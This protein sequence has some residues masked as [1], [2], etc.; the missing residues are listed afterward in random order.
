MRN[1]HRIAENVNVT[2]LMH[3][4]IRNRHLWNENRFRTEFP[5]TPHVDVDDIWLRFS[6]ASKCDTTSTVIGD[7][8]P[9]WYPARE[10]LN[11]ARPIILDLMRAVG[12]YELGRVLITRIPKG[13]K[14]LPHRDAAGEYVQNP[15]I[16]RYHVV[17]QGEEGSLY[18]C[19][20]GTDESPAEVVQMRTGEVWWFAAL[21]LHSVENRSNTDRIHMLVDVRTW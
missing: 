1:F 13:G 10:T 14:I 3:Q 9:V 18:F 16:A 20:E 12:A 21:D 2:P 19:G 15:D 7:D 6:D 5:N 4:L 17:L 11:E 8:K